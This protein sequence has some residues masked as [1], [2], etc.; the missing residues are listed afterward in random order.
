MSSA[1]R[2]SKLT[3]EL[4]EEAVKLARAGL[5]RSVIADAV[6][7]HP[8][9][10]ENWMR[11]G[12]EDWTPKEGDHVPEDRAPY[13]AFRESILAAQA[14]PVTIAEA[15]WMQAVQGKPAVLDNDG[16]VVTPA[17]PGNWKAARDW[18]RLHRPDLY[19]E[20]IDA[21]VELGSATAK[22]V[23]GWAARIEGMLDQANGGD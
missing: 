3:P 17:V 19:R 2:K 7:I 18:L 22:A 14:R 4:Q 23:E 16:N 12:N 11:Y 5:A 20:G 15:T 9:T 8:A 1:G 21:T 13:I 10:L 6:G